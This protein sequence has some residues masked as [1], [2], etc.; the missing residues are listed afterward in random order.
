MEI[1]D[2]YLEIV[3]QLEKMCETEAS[4]SRLEWFKLQ[5]KE[6]GLKSYG[7]RTPAVR[8]LLK[9]Y[10]N[11]FQQ[12]SLKDRFELAKMFYESNFIEQ[13]TVGDTLLELC[14]ESMTPNHFDLLD[15]LRVIL[16]TGD[17]AARAIGFAFMFCSLCF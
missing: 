1:Q 7:I 15:E 6:L 13:A 17:A 11:R 14:G 12:L 9:S 2:V 16:T 4:I 8:K 3:L 10:M 5:H